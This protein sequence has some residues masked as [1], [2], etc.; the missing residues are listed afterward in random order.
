[1]DSL[2]QLTLGAACAEAVIGKQVGRKAIVW[3]AVLG[4][5]PDLDVFIP[6]GGPVDDFVYHRGFSHS[7]ILL[8]VLSPL[9]AW[10]ITKVH[11]DTQRYYRRWVLL[12]LIILEAGVLLDLLT[13]YGTQIFWPFDTTPMALPVLFIIDPF[14]TLPMLAGVLAALVLKRKNALGHRLNTAGLVLSL[15]YLVWA[16][17]AAEFVERRVTEKLARQEVSHSQFIA[18]PAPFNTLLWRIVGLNEDRYFETYFSLFDGATPLFVDFYPRNSAL[19]EGI[20]DHPPV[21]KLKWFTRGYYAASTVGD[22][23]AMTDLRMGSEPDYVF[24]FK[25]AQLNDSHVIPI[26]DQRLEMKR[27]WRGLAWIWKRIWTPL[28]QR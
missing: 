17:A 25:V 24:R 12:S 14:F 4:T 9:I 11:P 27:D 28:P 7:L 5:L 18:S 15:T 3:G 2:T 1:M 16:F 22:Y 23:I 13:I 26:E 10:L 6:L 20:E 19:L 21:A 8:A